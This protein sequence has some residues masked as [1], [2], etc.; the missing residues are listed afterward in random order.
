MWIIGWIAL[1]K[2]RVDSP[3][4]DLVHQLRAWISIRVN[5]SYVQRSAACLN[6]VGQLTLREYSRITFYGV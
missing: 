6:Y 1:G 4:L 3:V 2:R 5:Q